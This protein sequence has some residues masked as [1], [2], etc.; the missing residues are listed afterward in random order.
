LKIKR[1]KLKRLVC[2]PKYG[3][4]LLCFSLFTKIDGYSQNRLI[5][6]NSF[7][8]VT[9][10]VIIIQAQ[11]APFSDT[12]QFIFDTGSSGISLD[13][14][15]AK[16]LG[17]QPTY[18][19]QLI[20]GVGG[21]REVPSLQHKS[22]RVGQLQADSLNFYVNDYSVLTSI[23]GVRIDG[24]IG[25]ALI[26][27]FIIQID[28]EKQLMSWFTP[29]QFNYPR[30]GYLLRPEINKLPA[31]PV[32]AKDVKLDSTIMMLDIGAGLNL[33]FS[34][35]YMQKSGLLDTTRKYWTTSGEGVGGQIDLKLTVLLKFRIGPYRFRKIPI[36]IF[37]DP[38]NVTNFPAWSGLIGNDLLRRFNLIL[39]YPKS[40]I[41]FRPNRYFYEPFDYSY[42]GM[43]LYLINNQVEVGFIAPTS[44]AGL[45][46]IEVGDQ[47]LAINKVIAGTLDAYKAELN[48]TKKRIT[49]IYKRADKVEAVEI[50]VVKIN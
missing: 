20:R 46:G 27:R 36:T 21:I 34:N 35:R 6:T 29:G 47:I 41:H 30:N 3:L 39:N 50:K 10:G 13:S 37:E 38:Y 45:A 43:E 48:H 18:A 26:S 14:S 11:L 44:P 17:L 49:L 8:Q 2:L 33:L 24:V 12:L 31:Y 16:Y 40:E 25:Y 23:Y 15:T 22:L 1:I 5:S 9:G 7:L 19:G 28:Y 32:L 42:T 4:V